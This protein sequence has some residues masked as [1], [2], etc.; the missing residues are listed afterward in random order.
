[1]GK[2][3]FGKMILGFEN[4]MNKFT[5][6]ISGILNWSLRYKKTT[7]IIVFSL[8]VASFAL[9]GAGFV[10][11]DFFPGSDR[12]EFLVQIEMPKD[13]SIE[14]TN[15]MTQKAEEYLRTKPEVTNLIT[16][17][18]QSSDGMGASQA[19]A[20]KSEISV[21]LVGKKDRADASNIYAAKTKRELDRKSDV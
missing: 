3:F 9:V 8:L 12:G 18:G 10:G 14:Q 5:Q 13:V 7:L 2:G 17:V 19:P 20:Y 11:T 15:Q 16:T 4:G 1:T 21:K 6:F